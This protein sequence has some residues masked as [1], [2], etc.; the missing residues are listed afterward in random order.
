VRILITGATGFIGSALAPFLE[1]RQHQ[2]LPLRRGGPAETAGPAWEPAANWVDLRPAGKLDAVVHLAGES[3]AQR[4]TPA[5]KARIKN[6]REHGTR[7]L[8]EA[9][10][11]L[12]EP[13]RVLVCASAIGFY[14]DRG[15][16]L[17]DE[18]SSPGRGF[19]AEVCQ[20]WEAAANVARQR[21]IRVVHLRFGV[22]LG[23]EG[24]A[25][26]KMR[27]VFRFG[28]GGRLGSGRQYWSWVALDDLLRVIELALSDGRIRG[29][30]NVVAP[31][32]VTNKEFTSMLARVLRRPAFMTVPAFALKLLLGEM[33]ESLLA[34]AR[35]RPARLAELGFEFQF[36]N[37][38]PAL[39]HLIRCDKAVH[40]SRE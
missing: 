9:L 37:L 7:L 12:P 19:L 31:A 32:A 27:R 15:E 4:W 38:E 35:V 5:A 25:L 3:I 11:K 14:G 28:L 2:V 18:Q 34:S 13:P 29:P 23:A 30:V 1:A 17:L 20:L 21:G 10:A 26:P 8:S 36:P 39:R 16:E 22:V 24:G 40:G 33:G 6:S